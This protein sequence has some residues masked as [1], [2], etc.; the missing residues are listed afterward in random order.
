MDTDSIG[1][2]EKLKQYFNGAETPVSQGPF[3]GLENKTPYSDNLNRAGT[4]PHWGIRYSNDGFGPNPQPIGLRPDYWE[5]YAQY[6]GTE[7]LPENYDIRGRGFPHPV[8]TRVPELIYPPDTPYGEVNTTRG[9]G[10]PLFINDMADKNRG[11]PNG[12][13]PRL[14]EQR[15]VIRM[16]TPAEKAAYL[17]SQAER[18]FTLKG[19]PY[20]N[21]TALETSV[22]LEPAIPYANSYRAGATAEPTRV[23][24]AADFPNEYMNN[25]KFRSYVNN[26]AVDGL[27]KAGKIAGGALLVAHGLREGPVDALVTATM[28]P[29]GRISPISDTSTADYREFIAA[30]QAENARRAAITAKQ[31]KFYEDN[32]DSIN[33]TRRMYLGR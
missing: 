23:Y 19:S 28:G 12:I 20:S 14:T 33:A 8:I 11:V 13:A 10:A 29:I 2:F 21:S 15:R 26:Y 9:Y 17:A 25:P 16:N 24:T 7:V 22:Q 31:I 5:K 18:G 27:G 4:D 32:S 6:K 3:Y 30:R 1:F